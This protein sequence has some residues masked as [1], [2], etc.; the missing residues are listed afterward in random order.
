[1]KDPDSVS[2]LLS[3]IAEI[4]RGHISII[5]SEFKEF[6]VHWWHSVK[7]IVLLLCHLFDAELSVEMLSTFYF[8]IAFRVDIL[9]LLCLNNSLLL[10]PIHVH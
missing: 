10:E 1:M 4:D 8:S 9:W 6:L 2:R 7:Q 5:S 3:V